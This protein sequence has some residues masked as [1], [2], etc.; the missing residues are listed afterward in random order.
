MKRSQII[1]IIIGVLVLIGIVLGFSFWQ[2]EIKPKV[3]ISV[4]PEKTEISQEE[5]IHFALAQY[6]G[7]VFSVEKKIFEAE[8]QL[9]E[10]QTFWII[11]INLLSPI[12]VPFLSDKTKTT[13]QV[14]LRVDVNTKEVSVYKLGE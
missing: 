14:W 12:G 2:K 11:G 4:P 1:L 10:S 5:A 9:E 8:K 6:P 13:S 3:E 7:E